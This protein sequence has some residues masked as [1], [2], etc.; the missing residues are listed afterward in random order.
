M[1]KTIPEETNMADRI[2]LRI[3]GLAFSGIT[4][5]VV[6]AAAATVSTYGG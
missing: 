1:T 2:G 4:A 6:L 5:A 3:I